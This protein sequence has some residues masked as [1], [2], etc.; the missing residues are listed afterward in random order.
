MKWKRRTPVPP[1]PRP[2]LPQAI[3]AVAW[4]IYVSSLLLSD[5][6]LGPSLLHT[7]PET[8]Q[9]ALDL[10]LNFGFILPWLALQ[11]PQ[12][13]VPEPPLRRL[14]QFAESRILPLGILAVIL[15]AMAGAIGGR[16]DF[17]D[18]VTRWQ[19]LVDLFASD[20]LTYCFGIDL[21]VFWLFQGWLVGDDLT[22]RQWQAPW[23]LWIARLVPCF[24]LV[25]YLGLRP[26]VLTSVASSTPGQ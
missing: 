24:G 21:L 12:P 19:G 23:L 6:L 10:S 15:A 26:A 4:L 5:F 20:R 8:L 25:I 3:A 13:E 9:T 17:S 16:P 22:R 2:G 14:E 11:A 7:E 18:G 1:Q